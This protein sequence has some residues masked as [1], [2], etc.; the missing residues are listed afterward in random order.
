MYI[1]YN[2]ACT[3]DLKTIIIINMNNNSKSLRSRNSP[4][5]PVLAE[6]V[7]VCLYILSHTV[8]CRVCLTASNTVFGA[9]SQIIKYLGP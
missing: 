2:N 6:W 5:V 3:R 1:K 7:L 9:D 4:D 8:M